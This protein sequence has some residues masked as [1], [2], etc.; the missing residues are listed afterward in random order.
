MRRKGLDP[1]L[2]T[3]L[4]K[5][6][7]FVE[8]HVSAGTSVHAQPRNYRVQRLAVESPYQKTW[9]RKNS[10]SPASGRLT[11]FWTCPKEPLKL[12]GGW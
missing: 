5:F 11:S 8:A 3:H 2:S 9:H 7:G 6:N 1:R 10:R 4:P 12:G